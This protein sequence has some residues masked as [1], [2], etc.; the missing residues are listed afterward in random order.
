MTQRVLVRESLKAIADF[1]YAVRFLKLLVTPFE[2]TDAFKYGVID[3]KGKV[4]KKGKERVTKDEKNSYTVFHRLVF[5]LKKI[6]PLGKLGSYASALFLIREQTGMSD[7]EIE[8]ALS[9]A[10]LTLNDFIYESSLYINDFEELKPGTYILKQNICDET[11]GDPIFKKGTKVRCEDFTVP[12]DKVLN[13]NI[14]EAKHI[15][16]NRKVY[17]SQ[18]DIE[19]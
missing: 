18:Y 12:V 6:I 9:K 10:E 5:N 1:A 17:I 4:L 13:I 19:R 15:L 7:E 11:T 16:T 3:A 14:Y 8:I 2:K